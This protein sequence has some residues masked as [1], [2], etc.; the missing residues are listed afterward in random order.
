MITPAQLGAQC[1]ASHQDPKDNCGEV[2]YQRL[3]LFVKEKLTCQCVVDYRG[4]YLNYPKPH[5][6]FR[7]CI[8]CLRPRRFSVAYIV[9]VCEECDQ[10]YVPRPDDYRSG[11]SPGQSAVRYRLC[12]ECS[13][14]VAAAF[15][16]SGERPRKYHFS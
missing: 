11:W 13:S 1:A 8:L 6:I 15:Q 2:V 14:P 7:Y 9:L 4:G 5:D 10:Y 3:P 12:G 16:R